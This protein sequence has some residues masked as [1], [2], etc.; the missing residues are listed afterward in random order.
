MDL[1][2]LLNQILS[3]YPLPWHG[4]H[5]IAHWARVLENGLKLCELTGANVQVVTL[6]AILH[7]SQRLNESHDPDYGP[8]A[9]QFAIRIRDS[10]LDLNDAD[11]SLLRKACFGHT[12][13]LKHPDV[14]VQTCWDSDRLD[15][16]RVGIVPHPSRLCTNAAKQR[17]IINWAHGRASLGVVPELVTKDWNIRLE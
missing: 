7:D 10:Y 17:E 11:F 9:E 2:P 4:D 13:E 1:K 3:D 8:R 14:T 5:G 12:H 15:L 16:G 6:F